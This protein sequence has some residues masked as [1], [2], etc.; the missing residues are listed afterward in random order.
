MRHSFRKSPL[1]GGLYHVGLLLVTATAF[2]VGFLRL[3]GVDVAARIFAGVAL[4]SAALSAA[5]CIAAVI[6]LWNNWVD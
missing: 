5:I 6:V 3:T 1:R 2:N 4:P